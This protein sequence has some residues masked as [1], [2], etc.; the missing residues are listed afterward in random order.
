MLCADRKESLIWLSA[1]LFAS[2]SLGWLLGFTRVFVGSEYDALANDLN[3][4]ND[5]FLGECRGKTNKE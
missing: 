5:A 1:V 4:L 3:F 2:N